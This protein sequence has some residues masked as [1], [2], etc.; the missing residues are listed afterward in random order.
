MYTRVFKAAVSND[1]LNRKS[2]NNS[3]VRCIQGF[4]KHVLSVTQ[5]LIIIILNSY[6]II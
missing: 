1:F 6:Y 5:P 4:W 3:V 2:I